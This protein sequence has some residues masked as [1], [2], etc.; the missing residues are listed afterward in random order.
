MTGTGPSH[1]GNYIYK[2]KPRAAG[3]GFLDAY[4]AHFTSNPV[5]DGFIYGGL[6]LVAVVYACIC[7]A[8]HFIPTECG[9]EK[10]ADPW[11]NP[12]YDTDPCLDRRYWQLLGLSPR[13]CEHYRRLVVSLLLGSVIGYERRSP[14]RPAGEHPRSPIR[15][16]CLLLLAAFALRWR[17]FASVEFDPLANNLRLVH[18]PKCG[19]PV[20]RRQPLTGARVSGIRTMSLVCLGS[21]SFT[22]SSQWAFQTSPMSWDAARVSAS[23]PS[24]ES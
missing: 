5:R 7:F 18:G 15:G 16:R 2:Y 6:I 23:I 17:P 10:P 14:D 19:G 20:S 24:G 21:C 1:E 22:L 12:E 9:E 11:P 3:K 4:L 13:E 8:E